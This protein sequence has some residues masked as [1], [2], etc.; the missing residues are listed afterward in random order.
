MTL[1]VALSGTD[2]IGQAKTGTGKTLGFGLPLLER[3]T[4]PAD[5]EAGRAKPEAL[6][7]SP[8]ALVVVPTRELCTQV[9]NDLLTAGKVRNVR[10]TAIYGGR[11]YEPQV[12]A[13]KKGVDVVVGTPGRL[14]DLAGQKKLNLKHVKCLVLDEADEMLDLGFLPD[15]EKIIN[16]LPAKRQTMLFSATMPGAVIGLARRYMS[17]PTHIRATAPDDQGATVA[18]IAQHVFRAHSMDK[19]EMVSRILQAE[20]RA[21][22]MIFCRTK[23]T[24]ADIAEQ[25]QRRGFAAGAVHGDLG[26]GAREQALRAFRN[27]KVDVLVCTDVAARGIDVEG[28]THV[29]NYQSPEDEKTYL[30]RIGRTGR[31]GA[32]G[33][34]I[35]LVDWDDIPRWQLINKALELDF[36]DPVETYSTSPHLFAVLGIPEGT[37]GVLPRSERTRAGLAAEELE[38]LGET[39]GRGPRDRRSPAPSTQSERPARTSRNR[40]RTRNGAPVEAP[41]AP[42]AAETAVDT[43]EALEARTPRRRRRMRGGVPAESAAVATETTETTVSEAAETA[44]DTA[45]PVKPRRR[46][47]RKAAETAPAAAEAAVDA[48]EAAPAAEAAVD[49]AETEPRRRTRKAVTAEAAAETAVVTAEA[50]EAKP[51][52]R[53]RK[54]AEVAP[55]VTEGE[56][57]AKPRRTRK[58]A[59]AAAGTADGA[60]ATP[61]RRTRKAATAEAAAETAVDTAEATEAKPRRRTR[62][63]VAAEPAIPAQS[64]EEPEVKP[65][66]RT[67]KAADAEAEIPAQPVE[68]PAKPRRRTRKAA[69][70][71]EG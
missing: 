63:T 9:T 26:Q 37:K 40:R 47:T 34:A 27:G 20:G 19:P 30:H 45:E 36:N 8:Q 23:R 60:E 46:R 29:I 61:R 59:E 66:R 54:T 64:V 18:N 65:R 57:P 24:A 4:V 33:T 28:V 67:R 51:R 41:A 10:V 35:T 52:R 25:L 7:D 13:L 43:A 50:T 32:S 14:L 31:A 58:T 12:E 42:D 38:D 69:E 48:V 21:L 70:P 71:A 56:A 5:V 62:K 6:T 68:A 17:Q 49:T 39:G 1:P 15:V 16:M 3:V 11:A 22:A 2:V 44:V 53:T 55:E